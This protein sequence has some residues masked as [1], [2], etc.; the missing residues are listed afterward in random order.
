[1]LLCVCVDVCVSVYAYDHK[2]PLA[3]VYTDANTLTLPSY[4]QSMCALY[5]HDAHRHTDTQTQTDKD[6][7]TLTQ[8]YT[9]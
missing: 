1:M 8:M 7:H 5:T 3:A 2:D 4:I 6:T 9:A